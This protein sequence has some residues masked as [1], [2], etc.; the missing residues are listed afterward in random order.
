MERILVVDDNKA[1]AK[2]IVMQMEKSIEDMA[3]DVAYD[4]AEAKML[5]SEHGKD[6]F[7]T[8]L[9]LNL[10]DAPNGEIVDYVLAQGLCAI[11]L[12]GSIDDKTKEF[13]INK[14]IVD[15]VYKGNMDDINYIFQMINRLSKNR[16]YKVLVVEDSL[17]FRNMIKKNLN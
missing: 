3:I 10:P 12:T 16:Q 7:M 4:F 17:P 9:D 14:D 6:Y 8:I 13:F 11:V 2:L 15:Y 1:L 5:I